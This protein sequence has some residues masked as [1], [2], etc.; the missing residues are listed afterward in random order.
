MVS[1]NRLNKELIEIS[2]SKDK[3]II[4]QPVNDNLFHWSG[5]IKGPPDTPYEN[6]WFRLDF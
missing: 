2:R 5:Y 1:R 3:D 4:L 6:G